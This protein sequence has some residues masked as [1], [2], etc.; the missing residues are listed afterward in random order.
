MVFILFREKIG[1]RKRE[2]ERERERETESERESVDRRSLRTSLSVLPTPFSGGPA[3]ASQPAKTDC[4][5]WN[6]L[7]YPRGSA[8]NSADSN[9]MVYKSG[10]R[11]ATNKP[12]L[13]TSRRK[14]WVC[15][16][17]KRTRSPSR[18]WRPFGLWTFE[19]ESST[20]RFCRVSER[21]T[22]KLSVRY[23]TPWKVSVES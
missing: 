17:K 3:E 21:Q 23:Q 9:R 16:P 20:G 11:L 13:G 12:S 6:F 2:R 1:E 19:R 14:G 22:E 5:R 15:G 7:N 8:N 18:N 10:R 4:P